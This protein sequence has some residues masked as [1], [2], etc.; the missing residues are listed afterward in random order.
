MSRLL[1]VRSMLA[2]RAADPVDERETRSVAAFE[3]ALQKLENPFDQDAD[4]THVTSSAIIIGD[5]G[6]VLHLHKRLG[7]WIQPGGHLEPGEDLAA[8]AMR[9]AREETGLELTHPPDGPRMVHVDVHAGGRGHTHLDL[10][11]LL[12]AEG[13]PRPPEGESQDVRWFG[14][15]EAIAIADPGLTGALRAMHP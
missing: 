1:L 9:E 4:P 13:T 10:R 3:A 15:D 7:I 2:L 5:A 8:G 12:H 11:W 6:V 14:W